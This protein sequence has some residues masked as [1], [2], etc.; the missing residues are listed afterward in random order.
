MT[1]LRFPSSRSA[2]TAARSSAAQTSVSP[3]HPSLGLIW[4]QLSSGQLVDPN[5]TVSS[6]SC[7][8]CT[9]ADTSA[10]DDCVISLLAEG[11]PFER[12]IDLD[13][14]EANTL[15]LFSRAGITPSVRHT[16]DRV[17]NIR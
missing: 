16:C 13:A 8:D 14:S 3:N 15:E 5:Q 6:I 4:G 17:I 9:M 7:G 10:C 12:R 11:P 1:V 2:R